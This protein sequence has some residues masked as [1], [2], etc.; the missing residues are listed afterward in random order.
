METPF[1]EKNNLKFDKTIY[2]YINCNPKGYESIRDAEIQ[3]SRFFIP[4]L[5][6]QDIVE[7]LMEEK[8]RYAIPYLDFSEIKRF[9]KRNFQYEYI[10]FKETKPTLREFM[11]E[12][13]T[14]HNE[15]SLLVFRTYGSCYFAYDKNKGKILGRDDLWYESYI[16]GY[17]KNLTESLQ[18]VRK[19]CS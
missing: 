14:K 5:S 7:L 16:H 10:A 12:Y 15:E 4:E 6:N 3:V 13:L 19:G 8:I 11:E 18:K 1:A 2:E 17:F 9:V